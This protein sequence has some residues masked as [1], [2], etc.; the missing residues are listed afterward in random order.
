ML[1]F[2]GITRERCKLGRLNLLRNALV[3][4]NLELMLNFIALIY[5]PDQG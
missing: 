2:L 4:V 3:N 5:L 1:P